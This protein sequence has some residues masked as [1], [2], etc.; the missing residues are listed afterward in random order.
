MLCEKTIVNAVVFGTHARLCVVLLV[1]LFV[2]H[3]IQFHCTFRAEPM[4]ELRFG[5]FADVCF[6]LFPGTCFIPDFFATCAGRKKTA[7]DLYFCPRLINVA[8]DPLPFVLMSSAVKQK[9]PL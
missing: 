8:N 7:Q 3:G 2:L 6:H 5:M 9:N 1:K 4:A